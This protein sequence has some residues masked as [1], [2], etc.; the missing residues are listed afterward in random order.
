MGLR[1]DFQSWDLN[2]KDPYLPISYDGQIIGFCKPNYAVR[3]IKIL[4]DEENSRKALYK[5]C[6]DLVAFKGGNPDDVKEYVKKYLSSA[7][8]PKHGLG[9]IM[10]LLRDRQRELDL[11]DPEFVKFCDS[12]KLS[13][14]ELKNVCDGKDIKDNSLHAIARILGLSF[15]D[16]LVIR[17][18]FKNDD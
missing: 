17:Y 16:L 10:V 8:R 5:A 1:N 4:N 3:I 14:Q 9:A 11:S 6:Q 7:K 12:Y 2:S 18:G 15:D 13:P